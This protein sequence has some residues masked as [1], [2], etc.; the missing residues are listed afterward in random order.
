MPVRTLGLLVAT[1]LVLAL[2]WHCQNLQDARDDAQAQPARD[3]ARQAGS[4]KKRQARKRPAK[5][6]TRKKRP[7]KKTSAGKRSAQKRPAQT[8]GAARNTAQTG[9]PDKPAVP[10][11]TEQASDPRDHVRVATWNLKRL[12][13]GKK[14][15]DQVAAIIEDFDVVALQE[16]MTSEG[17]AE[18]L[19]YLPGW[20]AEVSPRPVGRGNYQEWYAVLYRKD[21]ITVERAYLAGDAR[22]AFAR[23]PFITCLR[24]NFFDFCLVSIHVIF[25]D[26][27]RARDMEIDALG[28]LTAELRQNGHQGDASAAAGRTE[29]RREKDWIVLGDFNR[30]PEAPGFDTLLAAGWSFG[31]TGRLPTSLGKN[32]YHNPYDHIL[33]DRSVTRE[34][35]GSCTRVDFVARACGNDFQACS[36]DLSDHAPVSAR[37]RTSGPDDD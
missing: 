19:A 3:T 6:R 36:R 20:S 31:A 18:L 29:D 15:L 33:V 37:F 13:H 27:A 22:D 2:Q 10:A 8:T 9:T 32:G 5:T 16:V 21:R 12:G 28:R 23:E 35:D 34:L 30:M 1:L 17:V 4:E 11:R 25:G 14:K 24:A 7:A 26:S